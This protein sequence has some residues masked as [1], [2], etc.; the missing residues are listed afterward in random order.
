MCVGVILSTINNNLLATHLI[1][2]EI[3]QSA[4][5]GKLS[6]VDSQPLICAALQLAVMYST[7]LY[8]ER[9]GQTINQQLN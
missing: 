9:Q 6:D 8:L 5:T 7:F 3:F 1:V 2:A 4:V